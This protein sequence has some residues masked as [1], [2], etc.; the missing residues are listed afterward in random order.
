MVVVEDALDTVETEED[1]VEGLR[2]EVAT[3]DVA[4]RWLLVDGTR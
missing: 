1:M 4:L 3:E 2:L